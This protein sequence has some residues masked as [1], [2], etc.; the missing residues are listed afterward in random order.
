MIKKRQNIMKKMKISVLLPYKENFSPLYPGAISIF[1][2]G[3]ILKSKFKNKTTVYGNT[4]YKKKLN[5]NY[6]NLNITK[7][8]LKSSTKSYLDAFI[9]KEFKNRSDLIE[10]HNRPKY[11]NFLSKF[12][13]NLVLF[14]HNDPMDMEDSKTIT[15]RINLLNKTKKIILIVIGLK[16]DFQRI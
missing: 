9:K 2:H 5:N 15:Q 11:I 10:I 1:L 6:I 4:K 12:F 3:I 13:N 14:F 8:F 7:S 16:K